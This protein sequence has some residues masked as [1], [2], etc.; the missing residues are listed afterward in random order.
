MKYLA[1]PYFCDYFWLFEEYLKVCSYSSNSITLCTYTTFN[2][3]SIGNPSQLVI[4]EPYK[5]L[6]MQHPG[7]HLAELWND[8]LAC[9]LFKY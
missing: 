5:T 1:L 6:F 7:N 2:L 4:S 9:I 8:D 3:N